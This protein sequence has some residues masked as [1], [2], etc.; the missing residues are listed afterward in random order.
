MNTLLNTL[1]SI[2]GRALSLDHFS[3]IVFC[4]T[5]IIGCRAEVTHYEECGNKLSFRVQR[6]MAESDT[7]R[8]SVVVTLRDSSGIAMEF[9]FLSVQTARVALGHLTQ[10]EISIL[11]KHTN[12][13][14]IDTPKTRFPT[15]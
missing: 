15:H 1:L 6:A 7:A 5:I 11:C 13:Q 9:P 4:V 10:E 14:Y 12:V 8:I 2:S 3:F